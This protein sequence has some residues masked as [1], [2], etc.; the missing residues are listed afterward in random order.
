MLQLSTVLMRLF[1]YPYNNDLVICKDT[2]YSLF[3][4]VDRR[5]VFIRIFTLYL[6]LQHVILILFMVGLYI[7]LYTICLRLIYVLFSDSVV[8]NIHH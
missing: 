1:G 2:L 4:S 5:N 7:K 8:L 6:G 3:P